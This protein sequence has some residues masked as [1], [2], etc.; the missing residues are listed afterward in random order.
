M[1]G[2]THIC[3]NENIIIGSFME[4]HESRVSKD[5]KNRISLTRILSKEEQKNFSSFRIY[6]EGGKIILE[7]V[8]EIPPKDH[9]IYKNPEA[10]ASLMKGLEQVKEGKTKKLSLKEIDKRLQELDDESE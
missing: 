5:D 4:S 3:Y 8:I 2:N 6:R 9:W 1:V 10:L 7:P